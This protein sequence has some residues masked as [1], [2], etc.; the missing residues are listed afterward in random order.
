MEAAPKRASA[1]PV[2]M[3]EALEE[4]LAA[5]HQLDFAMSSAEAFTDTELSFA[6][7]LVLRTLA[8]GGEIRMGSFS[9]T[10]RL[11]RQRLNR[12]TRGLEKKGLVAIK[13]PE[14]D[15]RVRLVSITPSGQAALAKLREGLKD[16]AAKLGTLATKPEA[17][18]RAASIAGRVG[19]AAWKQRKPTA[20]KDDKVSA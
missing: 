11:S 14:A 20:A 9:Q 18:V 2:T 4:L 19:A 1:A 8:S 12:L 6:D 10:I 3:S 17:V 15:A 13:S 7:M 5:T 16:V